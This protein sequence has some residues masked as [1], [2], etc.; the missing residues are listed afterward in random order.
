M[1][2][3]TLERGG[4]GVGVGVGFGGGLRTVEVL[5]VG[6]VRVGASTR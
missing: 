1:P 3:G 2:A 5:L 6:D 4:V